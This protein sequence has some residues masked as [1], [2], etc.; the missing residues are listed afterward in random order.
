[1]KPAFTDLFIKKPVLAI[2]ISALIVIA[3]LQAVRSL[4]IRQYPL[5]ENA[6]ITI[7]TAYIGADSKLVRGFI[8]TPIEQAIATAD[9]IDYITSESKLGS[10]TVVARLKLNYDSTKALSDI[11]AKVD[12]VRGELPPEAEIPIITVA[13]ADS[14][15]ASAYLSFSSTIL[16]ANQ[17]TD[18]LMRV[19]QPRLN[20]ID[21]IQEARILGGRYY[22][23]RIWLDATKMAALNISPTEVNTA[24]RNENYLS[25]L[26]QTKGQLVTVNLTAD[27]NLSSVSAFENI[28]VKALDGRI[29][30]LRDIAEIELAAQSYDTAVRFAGDQ[31]VFIG[32]YVQPKANAV[33]AI[34]AVRKELV[35]IQ[36]ELPEGLVANIGYDSTVYIEESIQEVIHTL[37]ETLLIV[38][39]VIYLFMGRFRTILVPIL[40]IP[41][42][43][44]G[45]AFFMQLLGFSIN[46]L[47]LLAIV[48]SVGIVVD[49]AIIV[50]EN[51]ERHLSAGM[52]PFEAAL[53]GVRE[54]IGP[55]IATTLTLVAVYIPIAFQGGLTGSLFK[56]FAL[57]LSAAVIVSS[58]VALVLSPMLASKLLVAREPSGLAKW[59]NGKFERLQNTYARLVASTLNGRRWLVCCW[60]II[61]VCCAPFFLLSPKELA[62]NEDQGIIFGIVDAPANYAL[63]ETLRHAKKV[64]ETYLSFPETDYS[65]QLTYPNSGFSGMILKPWSERERTPQDLIPQVRD[66]F[67]QIS[68]LNAFPTT[69]P[70][71]PGGS[72]F[73]VEFIIAA[74]AEPTEILAYVEEIKEQAMASGRFAFPPIIDTRIDQPETKFVIDR[75]LVSEMGLLQSQ[76]GADLAGFTGGAYIN[77]FSMDGRSY[78]VIPQIMRSQRLN[79]EQLGQLYVKGPDESLIQLST[80]VELESSIQPRSLNRFQQYNAV[81]MSGVYMGPLEQGLSFL[82]KAA[83]SILPED[84]RIDYVGESRQLRT[85][86][87][88]FLPAFMLALVLIFMVLAAQFNSFRDPFIILLGSVP[89]AMFG[90]LIF[91]FLKMMSPEAPFWTDGWTTTLNIYSQVG[92]VT[93][94]GLVA[95]NGILI[96]EFA[97]QLQR[98]GMSK[99]NAIQEA[100]KVRLRPILMTTLAT[101][102]GHFPLIL[103][104]GA[105]AA[106][107][108]SIG[109]V[110]VGGMAIGSILTLLFLPA[111]YMLIAK[112]RHH[113]SKPRLEG[114]S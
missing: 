3:G 1:M 62:P 55:V 47:T 50:V 54:L 11:S 111:I 87:N 51:I 23:M 76:I 96:V 88:K 25:A 12:Q 90:A 53:T 91:T 13:S 72:D 70:A 9:G 114:A 40:T 112:D 104:T 64:N 75:D 37:I 65:F 17:I 77:R 101:V 49:D 22:A 48:L 84:Y 7:Q 36:S 83:N 105:G 31:A 102:A 24:L 80:F 33:D 99:I 30:R 103:V 59:I 73:P 100:C 16:P 61:A 81:K 8:T 82:E 15:R 35:Q 45:A 108:N 93:L 38:I 39:F 28:N 94:I 95:K 46:L 60:L 67:N 106:A 29:I 71:L 113:G 26:G 20:T 57:T 44:I 110:L 27:S 21:G 4:S 69:P 85:E 10:S 14:E 109:L 98:E 6:K 41:I 58:V 5:N 68:G 66:A 42:S 79:P 43:L 56:E 97:N 92:L 89:L 74:A 78:K 52:R 107:R 18:Y 19:I 34:A 86:G 63:E 2:V 32:L